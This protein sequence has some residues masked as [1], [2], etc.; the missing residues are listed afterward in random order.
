MRPLLAAAALVLLTGCGSDNETAAT[1]T[2]TPTPVAMIGA[3]TTIEE[4]LPTSPVPTAAEWAT[5]GEQLRALL[6]RGDT[7][8]QNAVRNLAPAVLALAEEPTGADLLAARADLRE[9]LDVVAGYCERA[10]SSALQ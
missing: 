9:S 5:Y 4:Y 8:T 3:C 10:G 6:N 2:P 1:P 7:D